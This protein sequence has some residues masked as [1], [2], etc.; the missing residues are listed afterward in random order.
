MNYVALRNLRYLSGHV[1]APAPDG[2]DLALRAVRDARSAQ[3]CH[4]LHVFDLTCPALMWLIAN[5][6][7]FCDLETERLFDSDEVWIHETEEAAIAHCYLSESA[8]S[9]ELPGWPLHHEVRPVVLDPGREVLFRDLHCEVVD[10]SAD[11]VTLRST[12]E[13]EGEYRVFPIVLDDVRKLLRTGDLRAAGSIGEEAMANAR[14]ELFLSATPSQLSQ[15]IQ[16]WKDLKSHAEHGQVPENSSARTIRRHKQWVRQAQRRFGAGFLGLLRDRG[17]CVGP[18][19]PEAQRELIAQA[20]TEFRGRGDALDDPPSRREGNAYALFVTKCR[21]AGIASDGIISER[22]FRRHVRAGSAASAEASRR[23]ARAGYQLRGPRLHRGASLPRNGDRIWELAHVDHTLLDL[24]LVSA[25]TG[26]VLGRPWL[27]VLVDAFSRTVLAFRLSFDAPSRESVFAVLYDCVFRH[28]RLPEMVV[29]D[30]GPDFMS[31]DLDIALAYLGVSKLERPAGQARYGSVIERLFGSV[32]TRLVH[33]QPGST[34]PVQLGRMLSSSHRP[35]RRAAWTLRAFHPVVESWLFDTYP[36]LIHSSLGAK[37]R[38][39]WNRSSERCGEHV[40]RYLACDDSLRAAL[41]QSV[42][43]DTRKVNPGG[44]V[45]VNHLYF[46]HPALEDGR[47]LGMHVPVRLCLADASFVYVHVAH[48]GEWIRA[49]VCDGD[50]DL[51]GLSWRAV[52]CTVEELRGQRRIGRSSGARKHNAELVGKALADARA[53][54]SPAILRRTER[55]DEQS[56]L[57]GSVE[58]ASGAESPPG[59]PSHADVDFDPPAD[60]APSSDDTIDY[61]NLKGF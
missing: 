14:R 24:T 36:D 32:N 27:T 39:V 31:D 45:F 13:V 43:G 16:W 50:A 21:D 18:V 57:G 47:V 34:E 19:V 11:A 8:D 30:Q 41:S 42:N 9:Q 26:A 20:V 51:A 54:A 17:R 25:R 15:A 10:R 59:A 12:L 1:G 40:A 52:N 28:R 2:V 38:G 23:G 29:V 5:R 56:E 61:D 49:S 33:E 55:D 3:L 44:T 22:T 7:V 53:S 58:H 4:L 37:P 6:H 46:A 48:R 35:E 60:L